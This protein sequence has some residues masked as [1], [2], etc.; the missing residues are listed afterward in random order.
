MLALGLVHVRHGALHARHF[1]R[2]VVLHNPRNL[3]CLL[4]SDACPVVVPEER[5]DAL[6]RVGLFDFITSFPISVFLKCTNLLAC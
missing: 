1:L 6:L 5:A 4:G 3:L 2:V